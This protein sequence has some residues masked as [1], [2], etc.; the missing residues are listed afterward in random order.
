MRTPLVGLA[1]IAVVVLVPACSD[2]GGDATG[3]S[4]SSSA[5]TAAAATGPLSGTAWVLLSWG[6]GSTPIQA[7]PGPPATLELA[8]DGRL[9]GSTGCNSFT[10]N[11]SADGERLTLQPGP[12]TEAACTDPALSTQERAL[13]RLLPTVGEYELGDEELRL[14]DAEGSLLAVYMAQATD[15]TGTSWAVIGVDNGKGGLESSALTSAL[16]A[17]LGAGG[18]LAGNGGCNRLTGTWEAEG[19]SLRISGITSTEIGC[20]QDV[21]DLEIRYIQALEAT[22]TY[23][24]TGDSLTLRDGEGAM[25]VTLTRAEG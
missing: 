1:L 13:L 3:G 4:D 7:A 24:W 6:E 12:M 23:Q 5:T 20:D 8:A 21:T 10:G 2:D 17:E 22:R 16:T 19:D 15:L 14:T 11:W 25:V 9:A 18:E